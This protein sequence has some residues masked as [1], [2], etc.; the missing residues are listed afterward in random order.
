MND[1]LFLC[2]SYDCSEAFYCTKNVSEEGA[3]GCRIACDADEI[4]VANFGQQKWECVKKNETTVKCPG[5][6]HVECNEIQH[7][8]TYQQCDCDAQLIVTG[9]C[10]EVSHFL[11]RQKKLPGDFELVFSRDS[12]ADPDC[13]MEECPRPARIR[14]KSSP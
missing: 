10:K 7:N 2:P 5:R 14:M 1:H 8:I 12:S 13:Q 11:I 6:F 4:V 9:D 3:E